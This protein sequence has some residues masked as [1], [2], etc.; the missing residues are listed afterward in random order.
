MLRDLVPEENACLEKLGE[1]WNIYITL[2]EVHPA[3]KSEFLRALHVC[4]DIVLCR[5]A[6]EQVMANRQTIHEGED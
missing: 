2:L 4:Q 1:A 6:L 5:P 3:K